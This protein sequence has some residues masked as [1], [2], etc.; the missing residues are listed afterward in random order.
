VRAI[1]VCV[2]AGSFS[3]ADPRSFFQVGKLIKSCS[4]LPANSATEDKAIALPVF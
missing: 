4:D 1:S 3:G 2:V